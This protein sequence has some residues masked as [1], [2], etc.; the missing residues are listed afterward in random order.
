MELIY[1]REGLLLWLFFFVRCNS[2]EVS[3]ET[4]IDYIVLFVVVFTLTGES[5][6]SILSQ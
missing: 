3:T 2:D 6:M 5:I 1:K 4:C